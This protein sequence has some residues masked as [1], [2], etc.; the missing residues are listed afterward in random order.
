MP[1]I[2]QD[3]WTPY[4]VGK[5]ITKNRWGNPNCQL[6]SVV[7]H[8]THVNTALEV[9]RAGCIRPQ[10][11]YDESRL[12]TKRVLVVWIS[13]NDWSG[14]GGFRYGNIAFE[15]NW[16]DL[17]GSKRCYWVGVMKY[18]PLA[19]RILITDRNRDKNLKPYL[20]E[21]G[22]GPWWKDVKKNLHYWNGDYCL[23]FMLEDELSLSSVSRL[24]F[25][26]HHEKRCSISPTSCP[27][28][29]HTGARAAARLLAGACDRRLLSNCS[30]IWID[31]HDAPRDCLQTAWES[32]RDRLCKGIQDWDG[33]VASGSE[34]AF[35]IARAGLG[36]FCDLSTQDRK[37]LFSLFDSQES[38]IESCASIIE[39]DLDLENGILP[40]EDED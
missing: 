8:V 21:Q 4:S 27:D 18:K 17:V 37:Q 14:A 19:C 7:S 39:G 29:G 35:A 1:E 38:V 15:L 25:V 32:L 20:C 2:S 24:R 36:A 40:R 9:L 3:D 6:L 26:R 23:E 28:R 5:S 11:I 16:D 34:R 12:N 31:E 10:L 33:T 30:G 13:P 22:D